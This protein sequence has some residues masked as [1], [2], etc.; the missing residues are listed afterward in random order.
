MKELIIQA[1][2]LERLGSVTATY[3][4]EEKEESEVDFYIKQLGGW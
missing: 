3:L 1:A 2:E 4:K